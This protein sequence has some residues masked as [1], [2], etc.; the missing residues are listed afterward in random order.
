MVREIGLGGLTPPATL[1]RAVAAE[2]PLPL[3]VIVRENAGYGSDAAE[4]VRMCR[5][6]ATC[7]QIGVDGLVVGFARDGQLMLGELREVL[8]S[9]PELPATFHRAFDSVEDPLRAI[10]ALAEMPQIDRI[11]TDGMDRQ[12]GGMDPTHR[13]ARLRAYSER[14]GSRVI[15]VAGSAVDEQMLSEIALTRSVREVHVG[16]AARADND[17]E[18]PVTAAR[19]RRLREILDVRISP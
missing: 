18:G 16:R 15:I 8:D 19:V 7:A 2:T 12:P 9:A 11:L 5:A 14:A 3:R 6:A 13:C 17:P 1:V 4:L 10:D